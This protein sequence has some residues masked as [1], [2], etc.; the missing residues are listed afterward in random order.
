MCLYEEKTLL[1]MFLGIMNGYVWQQNVELF[2]DLIIVSING[3][4]GQI[5]S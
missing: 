2:V 3:T 5:V 1:E 4:I